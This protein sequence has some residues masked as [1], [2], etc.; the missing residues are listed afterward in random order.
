MKD[1]QYIAWGWFQPHPGNYK[2]IMCIETGILYRRAYNLPIPD[3]F[4]EIQNEFLETV[5]ESDGILKPKY[6]ALP[7]LFID[8][9]EH[10]RWLG[11]EAK[12]I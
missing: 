11:L 7:R 12:L 3:G 8:N 1:R 4:V 9:K 2:L 6:W 10:K 5:Y